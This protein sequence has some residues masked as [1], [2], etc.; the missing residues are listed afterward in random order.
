MAAFIGFSNGSGWNRGM[1][2]APMNMMREST[3]SAMM[4]FLN[5]DVGGCTSSMLLF[6]T[7]S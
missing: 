2:K 6:F 3:K 5:F 1:T 4:S 7:F